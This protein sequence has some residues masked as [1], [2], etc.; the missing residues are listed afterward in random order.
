[1]NHRYNHPRFLHFLF[2]LFLTACIL[3]SC[4]TAYLQ[5]SKAKAFRKMLSR[6]DWGTDTCYVYGHKTPDADAACSSLAYA[7]LMQSLGYNCVAKLSGP[8]NNE[9]NYISTV[10]DFQV[11]VVKSYLAPGTRLIATDHE[12]YSQ[13]VDGARQCRILQ[14]I[15]HHQED[16][17][18]S[19]DVAF[20]RRKT[21][22]ATCTIVWELYQEAAVPVDDLT[23][24]ILLAGLLSDTDNLAKSN[25]TQEDS[26]AWRALTAQLH[27]SPER[28]AEI[29]VGMVDALTNYNGMNDYEI[30]V[31]DYKDYDMS[32]TAVGIGCVEWIDYAHMDE[33]LDRML[34]VMPEVM[35]RKGRTKLFLMAT[36]YAPDPAAPGKVV[37]EGTYILYR[38]EGSREMAERAGGPSLRDGICYSET[39]LGR[40]T[41]VVP[42]FSEMLER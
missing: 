11:P 37:A 25:T 34:A 21:V 31:S 1:M 23:A 29:R 40:K 7:R 8:S 6:M 22:G 24:R 14:I 36:R 28:V 42:Q 41:H 4:G 2:S 32:G 38:G 39:R 12:E 30:F 33:F 13:A 26:V 5:N 27:L 9:T 18:A 35:A 15:D 3:A 17:M 16:D 19:P 10:F 20:I